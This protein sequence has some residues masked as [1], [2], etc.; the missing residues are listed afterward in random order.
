MPHSDKNYITKVSGEIV[1]HFDDFND[2]LFNLKDTTD[3]TMYLIVEQGLYRWLPQQ[4]MNHNYL[5]TP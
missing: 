2:F 5:N 1:R 3:H 4:Q